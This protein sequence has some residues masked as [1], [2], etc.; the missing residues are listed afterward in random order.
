MRMTRTIWIILGV[1]VFIAAAVTLYMFYQGQIRQQDELNTDLSAVNTE[2]A[3]LNLQKGALEDKI[4]QLENDIAQ[5]EGETT[6]LE[7]EIN[8][9]EDELSQLEEERAQA[10]AQA[11]ALLNSIAAEFVTS[12]ESIEY[13]EVMFGFA[14]DNDIMIEQIRVSEIIKQ[15]INGIEYNL[16]TL[17]ISFRGG[18]EDTLDFIDT[19]VAYDAFKSSVISYFGM[20]LP[21]PLNDEQIAALEASVTAGLYAQ[22]ISKI[23]TE[24][25][26]DF[27]FEALADL[28][29]TESWHDNE[30][31]EIIDMKAVEALAQ[32]I[33]EG[34][35]S[36]VEEEF[37]E[38]MAE[39]LT[40][41][42]LEHIQD[43]VAGAVIGPLAEEIATAIINGDP[44]LTDLVGPDLAKLLGGSIT[45]P[46]VGGITELLNEY[47]SMLLN[48]KLQDSVASEVIMAAPAAIEQAMG[49]IEM[50]SSVMSLGI[51]TYEGE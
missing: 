21:E 18:V 22:E 15:T 5:Q 26:I 46:L 30:F 6:Q 51:Y 27:I 40:Q 1:A 20:S 41:L 33:T 36:L 17:D 7:A 13:D 43:S 37:V 44:A 12:M 25:M 31:G 48:E 49:E 38:P 19:I 50:P 34:I 16:T 39:A 9:L 28:C 4:E 14:H 10:E 3:R 32:G 45:G 2:L 24:E 23:T 42:I 8:Q 11:M 29:G 47:F 35:D